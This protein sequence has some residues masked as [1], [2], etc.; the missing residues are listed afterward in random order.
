MYISPDPAPNVLQT[1][2]LMISSD[3]HAPGISSADRRRH[4]DR[5]AGTHSRR[6]R[7]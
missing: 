7:H 6:P 2:L 1:D 5:N 4:L 3:R